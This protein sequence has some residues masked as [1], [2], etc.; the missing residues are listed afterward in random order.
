MKNHHN[1][2]NEAVMAMLTTVATLGLNHAYMAARLTYGRTIKVR[3]EHKRAVKV[4]QAERVRR[5]AVL[6]I[7]SRDALD[8]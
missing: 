1:E 5:Y 7:T 4:V 3:V 2:D 6:G 8:N